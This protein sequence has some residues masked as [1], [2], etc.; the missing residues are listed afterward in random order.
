[1]GYQMDET[2]KL[3]KFLSDS[4]YRTL[5]ELKEILNT[6]SA[7]TVYRKLKKLNYLSSFSHRGK[8]YKLYNDSD[9]DDNGLCFFQSIGFSKYGNLMKTVENFTD[10]SPAGYTIA[11]LRNILSIEVKE[12]LLNLY[13]KNKI[14]RIKI[15]DIYVYFS[16]NIKR[17]K[18]Q[19]LQRK[20][21]HGVFEIGISKGT[22]T[23]SNKLKAAIIIFYSLLDEKQR[24]LFSGLE[25]FKLGHGGDTKIAKLLDLDV[26]TVSKGRKEIIGEITLT[27]PIR[28]KGGGR[29]P[30]EKKLQK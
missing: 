16:L 27:D 14:H 8:Y 13:K 17:Q 5:D 10:N 22:E 3:I 6:N 2:E 19:Q 26:H 11:E 12:P 24:R 7:M 15:Q 29:K 18:A 20:N 30:I 25:S 1:M 28:S 21:Q 23:F 4:K 9:F